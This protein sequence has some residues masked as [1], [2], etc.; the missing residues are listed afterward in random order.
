MRSPPQQSQGGD[1]ARLGDRDARAGS[2]TRAEH[3][4]GGD[5][6]AYKQ[7]RLQFAEPRA[8]GQQQGS[9]QDAGQQAHAHAHAGDSPGDAGRQQHT[10]D[11]EHDEPEPDRRRQAQ[12]A[13]F[14]VNAARQCGD[15]G[16]TS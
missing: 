15:D 8:E 13:H 7:G 6:H 9:Q 11:V 4:G 2:S 10:D 12:I 5:E 1:T 16:R 3:R 14:G